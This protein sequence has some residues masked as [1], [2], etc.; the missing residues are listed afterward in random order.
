[1]IL[2]RN[3]ARDWVVGSVCST[4]GPWERS[5]V[6]VTIEG[7]ITHQVEQLLEDDDKLDWLLGL[8]L[9]NGSFEG[10]DDFDQEVTQE[11]GDQLFAMENYDGES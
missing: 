2:E 6:Q 1:M 5:E 4:R 9:T 3:G 7:L 8:A 10:A 11:D